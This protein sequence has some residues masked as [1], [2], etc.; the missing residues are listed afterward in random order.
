T[1]TRPEGLIDPVTL[2][3]PNPVPEGTLSAGDVVLIAGQAT[4]DDGQPVAVTVNGA[5]VAA[6]DNSGR[7]FAPITLKPDSNTITVVASAA[8]D[9]TDSATDTLTL[10]GRVPDPRDGIDFSGLADVS[11][12]VKPEYGRTSF[13][14]GKGILYTDLTA[15]HVGSDAVRTPLLA[16]IHHISRAGVELVSPDGRTP[17]DAAV[18]SV[19]YYDYTRRVPGGSLSGTESSQPRVIAVSDPE[20][21]PF[22]HRVS[23]LGAINRPPRFTTAPVTEVIVP[24]GGSAAYTYAA[25]GADPDRN[26]TLTYRVV[27]GPGDLH[28]DSTTGLVQW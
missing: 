7:F 6:M 22:I 5:G 4:S 9:P 19:Q 18:P 24:T 8:A 11:T 20:K 16:A 12:A 2:T 21:E 17:A 15:R 1:S 13:H 26:D 3:V 28:I 14:Y 23:F 27:Q 25:Q 10:T